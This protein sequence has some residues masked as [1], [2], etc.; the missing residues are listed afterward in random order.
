MSAFSI[1]IEYNLII[2][3]A[4]LITKQLMLLLFNIL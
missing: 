1:K 3:F 4:T 2:T